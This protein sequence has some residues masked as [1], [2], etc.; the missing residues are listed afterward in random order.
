MEISFV[1]EE[2]VF[3][4]WER[5]LVATFRA[6]LGIELATPFPRLRH[7]EVMERYG[8]DKPDVRFG[9]ELVDVAAWAQKSEFKVLATPASSTR[10]P[11]RRR[12]SS[13]SS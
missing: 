12:S 1:E 4:V 6:S 7:A 8:S 11:S 3:A 13:R 5:V 10:C 9:L 2:D